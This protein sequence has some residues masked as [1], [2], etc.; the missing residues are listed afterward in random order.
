MLCE[1]PYV[2]GTGEA[3]PCG[4]CLPCLVRR[5]KLWTHRLM[6]E[7]LCHSDNAFVTLTYADE[8]VPKDLSLDPATFTLWLKRFREKISPQ[9][10]RFYGVGE[11]GDKS[12][13]PHYHALLFGYATCLR[14]RSM[15]S[16]TR[17]NC[18]S[19]CDLVRDTWG[20]GH[21]GL[22]SVTPESVGYVVSYI[23]KNMRR[24]DDHRL[25][26]RWPEFSRMSL[27]P[28]IGY[29]ALDEITQTLMKYNLDDEM[30]TPTQLGHGKRFRPLGRYL[31]SKLS[32]MIAMNPGEYNDEE[33]L[34]LWDTAKAA[35][36]QGGEIRRTYFKNL[37][38]DAAEQRV[39]NMKTRM[40]IHKQEKPL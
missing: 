5:K 17:V 19:Q 1:N 28:G 18:C 33:V 24:T 3:F 11:Y 25:N 8:F 26:G 14:G 13:R 16:K 29:G 37:L 40:K 4:K 12:A 30:L 34:A 23:V 27:R 36:P 2:K 7:S 15:Y 22:G 9:R 10:V 21:V 32:D 38:M 20:L 35:T 6:L 31:R 39:L